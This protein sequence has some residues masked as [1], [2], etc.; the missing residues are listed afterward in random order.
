MGKGRT[1]TVTS[2]D[3]QHY[4]RTSAGHAYTH[5]AFVYDPFD[6][7]GGHTFFLVGYSSS[8][9]LARKNAQSWAKRGFTRPTVVPVTVV[10]GAERSRAS[11]P[12]T[13]AERLLI[14]RELARRRAAA[15]KQQR[16]PLGL[17]AK[18]GGK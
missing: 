10:G 18:K 15:R 17:F 3:G 16:N 11:H 8:E 14:E 6:R 5:A 7:P 2:P 12:R 1:V 13:R 9:E 4:T